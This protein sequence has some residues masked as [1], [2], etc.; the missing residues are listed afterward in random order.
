MHRKPAYRKH[1]P[2]TDQSDHY[3]SFIWEAVKQKILREKYKI[4]PARQDDQN[5]D[6]T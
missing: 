3:P 4:E 6:L 2:K 1:D 5:A